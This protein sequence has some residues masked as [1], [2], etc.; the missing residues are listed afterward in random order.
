MTSNLSNESVLNRGERSQRLDIL[1]AQLDDSH[2]IL[3]DAN[4][5]PELDTVAPTE[6]DLPLQNSGPFESK[7]ETVDDGFNSSTKEESLKTPIVAKKELQNDIDSQEKIDASLVSARAGFVSNLLDHK[8]DLRQKKNAFV[9]TLSGFGVDKQ[10]PPIEE[11]EDLTTSRSDYVE[12]KGSKVKAETSGLDGE[13]YH[14]KLLSLIERET[15][16]L[17]RRIT[18]GVPENEAEVLNKAVGKWNNFSPAGRI[19]TSKALISLGLESISPAPISPYEGMRLNPDSSEPVVVKKIIDVKPVVPKSVE[20]LK[21]SNPNEIRIA[22]SSNGFVQDI[23]ALKAEIL[24]HYHDT[25]VPDNIKRNILDKSSVDLAKEFNLYNMEA[26]TS[27]VGLKGESIGID[28]EGSIF[29]IGLDG[30]KK[31]L[32]QNDSVPEPKKESVEKTETADFSGEIIGGNHQGFGKKLYPSSEQ[33]PQTT[34]PPISDRMAKIG[35]EI[36]PARAGLPETLEADDEKI[37]KQGFV[38][39]GVVVSHFENYGDGDI[40]VL[41]EIFQEDMKFALLRSKFAEYFEANVKTDVVGPRPMAEVFEGG[42]IYVSYG[43]QSNPNLIRVLLNGKEIAKG[44]I[45]NEKGNLSPV[46]YLNDDLKGGWIHADNA[47]ER[48][49]TRIAKLIKSGVFQFE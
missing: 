46:I 24:A 17:N 11:P 15:Q 4:N 45:R 13:V 28:I 18:E 41:N 37:E 35:N 2:R 12:A 7:L 27:G 8:D 10:L 34:L 20:V 33:E 14:S 22:V 43:L 3:D 44:S 42:K 38:Y 29:Y 1:H 36:K 40:P 19:G 26:N 32:S 25:P 39:E 49:F 16:I 30:N 5:Y 6:L 21:E 23:H 48:A 31:I 47:Y 9:K